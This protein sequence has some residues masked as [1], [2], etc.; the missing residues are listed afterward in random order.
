MFKRIFVTFFFILLSGCSA[1]DLI[2]PDEEP[3][4]KANLSAAEL[5][6][7]AK[8]SLDNKSYVNAIELYEALESRYPFGRYAQQ[9]QVELAYAYYKQ[10][11]PESAIA[12][13]NRFI[14]I[15][16]RHNNIAYL[17]YL[18]GLINF[19]RGI[20]FLDRYLPTDQSQRDPG[21]ALTSLDDF[22]TLIRRFPD[23]PYVADSK[24]R[25]ISLKS[26]LALHDLNVANYYMKRQAYVAAINRSKHIIEEYQHTTAVPRAL[27]LMVEAYQ[28]IGMN[29]LAADAQRVYS[30]N[31][32]DGLPPIDHPKFAH[33]PTLSEK[34]WDYLELDE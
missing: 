8:A 31:Y 12:T 30:L 20:G 25:I 23:S 29:D 9:S 24:Q 15:H 14:R 22:G 11:E 5:Y 7:E 1:I 17:Y 3:D 32:P 16:P 21:A 27:L 34:I 26:N 13:A 6:H 18:K 10:D 19:N 2:T 4:E 33:D 28:Y